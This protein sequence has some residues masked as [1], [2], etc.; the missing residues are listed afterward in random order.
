MPGAIYQ[1][2][3][4]HRSPLQGRKPRIREVMSL[5]KAHAA[6]LGPKVVPAGSQA[7]GGLASQ[8]ASQLS[9]L[10]PAIPAAGPGGSFM[11]GLLALSSAIF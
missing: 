5:G 3:N 8:V 1:E 2:E 7:P 6:R 10:V 11:M 4:N 9:W